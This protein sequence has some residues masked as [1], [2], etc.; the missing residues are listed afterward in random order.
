MTKVKMCGLRREVDIENANKLLPDYIGYVFAPKG[1]RYITPAAASELTKILDSRIIPVGV[2]VDEEV[3]NV[4]KIVDSGA[5][6]IVQ[7][8]GSE[9]EDYIAKLRA[10]GITVIKAFIVKSASDI[11]LANNSSADY[12]LL[13][14]GMGDG[15]Q[16]DYK[17][18]NAIKR[19]Y[20]LAGGLDPQNV[21]EAVEA[22]SPY[23]VD[24][25]SGIETDGYKS[26]EKMTAFINT[27]RRFR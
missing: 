23:A 17:L 24:V 13:D 4:I 14:A 25:S 5:I 27:V 26:L 8:H 18:L 10:N 2:F 6:K 20:F 9:D 22:L 7:L 3:G 19:P 11:G 12:V 1:K 15:K 21:G 16:F